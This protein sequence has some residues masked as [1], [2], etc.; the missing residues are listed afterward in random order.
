[1]SDGELTDLR[2]A[3]YADAEIIEIVLA[4]ALNPFTNYVNEVAQTDIDFPVVDLQRAAA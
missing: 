3:G 4:V 1:M 2:A